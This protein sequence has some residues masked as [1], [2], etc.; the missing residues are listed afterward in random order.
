MRTEWN[1]KIELKDKNVF[2]NISS[3][4]ANAFPE[5]LKQFII[6]HNASSPS[7]NCV[8]INGKERVYDE[9]LSFNPEE[10]EASTFSSAYEAVDNPAYIPF[11][12][13]PFG[14]Y[15]CYA[16]K[17][18]NIAFYFHEEQEMD[19]TDMSLEEFINSLH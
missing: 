3:E 8:D 9:T 4:F 13:D 19:E 18:G 1:F 6:E 17:N 11:A 15:F 2:N 16:I 14:N 5:D 12:K 10:T 7:N